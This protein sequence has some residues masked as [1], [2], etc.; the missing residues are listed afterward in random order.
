VTSDLVTMTPELILLAGALGC[1]VM[2]SWTPRRSLRRVAVLAGVAPAL[3]AAVA[4]R[5]LAGQP[6]RVFHDTLVL[7]EATGVL[8]VVV[9]LSLIAMVVVA[10]HELRTH[11]RVAETYALLLLGGMGVLLLGSA[12]DVAVLVCAWLLSSI[13]LYGL[14]GLGEHE[15]APEATMKTYLLGAFSGIWMMTGAGILFGLAGSTGY[16]SLSAQASGMPVV[17]LA[18]GV[19]L[20]VTGLLFKAGAVPV[21]LWVPDATQASSS[22]VAMFVTTLP[23]LG[24]V[25]AIGRLVDSLPGHALWVGLVAGL[26]A[27]SMSLGN[28]AALTQHSVRRLLAWSTVSQVGYLL[29]LAALVGKEA[30]AWPAL[31]FFV[32]AYAVTNLAAFAVVAAEPT[33]KSLGDWR[34][35]AKHR[36][37]LVAALAVSLLGLVGTPP[38]AV[39]VAKLLLLE[40]SWSAGLPWLTVL[41]AVNTL[42]SLGY[43][44]RWLTACL[45]SAPSDETERSQNRPRLAAPVLVAS[46]CA[47][48]VV[49]LGVAAGPVL[50]VAQ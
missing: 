22:A 13:P 42:I 48:V 47:T 5:D 41:V 30:L 38:S 24:A 8:R 46:T 23:K 26:G 9:G 36:P 10:D 15:A 35:V 37:V 49:I 32:G 6:T 31:A 4:A 17:G 16:L 50:S 44:L 3:S 7:D 2:G 18:A 11:A 1:L 21:H 20:V 39:F 40:V 43:Y 28:L 27:V 19:V 12:A 25:V 33:R 29:A 34:G 45:T 14:L